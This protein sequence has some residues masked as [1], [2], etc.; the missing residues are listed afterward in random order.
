MLKSSKHIQICGE[1]FAQVVPLTLSTSSA[2]WSD[3]VVRH[4]KTLAMMTLATD[5]ADVGDLPR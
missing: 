1:V 3:I 4:A 2:N 5:N